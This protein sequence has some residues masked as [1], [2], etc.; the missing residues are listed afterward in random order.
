MRQPQQ[1]SFENSMR[2]P[3]LLARRVTPSP[4]TANWPWKVTGTG[5]PGRM[6]EQAQE[7]AKKLAIGTQLVALI[8]DY[9]QSYHEIG[10]DGN[11]IPV[12]PPD[13]EL[14]FSSMRDQLSQ[15]IFHLLSSE[16]LGSYCSAEAALSWQGPCSYTRN[17]HQE[18]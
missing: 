8:L 11:C 2:A 10:L 3:S 9:P 17:N 6:V 13:G 16:P 7:D 5:P 15:D 12:E 18:T 1:C 4:G 14:Q